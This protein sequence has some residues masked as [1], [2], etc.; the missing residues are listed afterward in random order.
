MNAGTYV[1]A[2]DVDGEMWLL[3]EDDAPRLDAAVTAFLETGRD[4]LLHLTA[5]QGETFV[6]RASRLLYW[7]VS[8]PEGRFRGVEFV[9]A[10]DEEQRAARE[11]CGLPP[12]K[13]REKEDWEGE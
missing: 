1:R 12:D 9:A 4:S 8:T 7:L 13:P 6:I 2:W 3:V 5:I 10:S 11:A